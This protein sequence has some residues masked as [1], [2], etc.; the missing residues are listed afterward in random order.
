MLD[1]TTPYVA[2]AGN[3]SIVVAI[4]LSFG[5]HTPSLQTWGFA[6]IHTS[7]ASNNASSCVPIDT[8][9]DECAV[10][11]QQTSKSRD[12]MAASCSLTS[13][14]CRMGS[15][16][17]MLRLCRVHCLIYLAMPSQP[18]H[19]A[20]LGTFLHLATRPNWPDSAAPTGGSAA[21]RRL[22]S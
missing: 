15:Y 22:G 17:A 8:E 13:H 6:A 4:G 1:L 14:F 10:H 3:A 12:T 18:L 21:N 19:V 2:V 20:P 5:D 9:Y 11:P 7:V 16:R